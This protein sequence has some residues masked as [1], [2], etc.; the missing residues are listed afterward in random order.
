MG[1]ESELE[2]AKNI[3]AQIQALHMEVEERA[4]NNC[5]SCVVTNVPENN[6]QPKKSSKT[7]PKMPKTKSTIEQR[8]IAKTVQPHHTPIKNSTSVTISSKTKRKRNQ[9]T[10]VTHFS[11]SLCVVVYIVL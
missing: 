4:K 8:A 10:L 9:L 1:I 5:E 11:F 7:Q 3:L 6:P 2:E